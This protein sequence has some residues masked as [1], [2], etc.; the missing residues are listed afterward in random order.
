MIAE[1]KKLRIENLFELDGH[2]YAFDS[3]AID[4]CLPVFE[5]AKQLKHKIGIRKISFN[6]FKIAK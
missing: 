1:A 5:E 3:T 6:Y 4:L 2:V